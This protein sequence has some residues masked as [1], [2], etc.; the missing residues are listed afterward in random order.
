MQLSSARARRR[1]RPCQ[2]C[3][4]VPNT[5]TPRKKL[6][7]SGAAA[8]EVKWPLWGGARRPACSQVPSLH[9]AARRRH[10]GRRRPLT[11]P[12]AATVAKPRASRCRCRRRRQLSMLRSLAAAPPHAPASTGAAS[13]GAAWSPP[14]AAG[15]GAAG[16]AGP[17]PSALNMDLYRPASFLLSCFIRALGGV[18]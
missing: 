14:A 12:A 5:R 9:S 16:A 10:P 8:R 3:D 6:T 7:A 13:I 2:A 17:L 4:A 18:E 11:P 15:G 1:R